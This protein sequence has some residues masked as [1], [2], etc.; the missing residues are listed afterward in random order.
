[1]TDKT[2]RLSL[3]ELGVPQMTLVHNIN[4]IDV[5]VLNMLVFNGVSKQI[6]GN[7][8]L[9]SNYFKNTSDYNK[10]FSLL[11][12]KINVSY[13]VDNK[14][15]DIATAI[16]KIGFIIPE[17][18]TVLEFYEAIRNSIVHKNILFY[19]DKYIFFMSFSGKGSN[20]SV[21][22]AWRNKS[23][24]FIVT[25]KL[26]DIA[27]YGRFLFEYIKKIDNMKIGGCENVTKVF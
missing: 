22:I 24:I 14:D 3:N 16:N 4:F 23:K 13:T 18:M 20:K 27:E 11:S 15:C 26:D 6:L 5:D 7:E 19:N 8:K 12:K 17:G 10:Y 2:I 25:K 1:M 21:E 9:I